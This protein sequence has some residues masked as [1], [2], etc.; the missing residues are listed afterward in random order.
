MP[1][2]LGG[3][4]DREAIRSIM[5]ELPPG[6][7]FYADAAANDLPLSLAGMSKLKFYLGNDTGSIHMAAAAGLRCVGVCSSH[8]PAGL[9]YPLGEG[10]RILRCNPEPE[11]AGCRKA[12]CPFGTPSRCID[13]ITVDEVADAVCAMLGRE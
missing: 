9:W 7:A 3:A 1:V 2:F 13:A 12:E 10:H 11:C 5:K 6:R 4:Q 8:D